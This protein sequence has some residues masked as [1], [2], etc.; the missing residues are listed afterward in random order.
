MQKCTAAEPKIRKEILDDFY[1]E[2]K[3]VEK[4]V[5]VHIQ[6]LSFPRGR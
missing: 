3:V 6:H 1:R 5:E 2:E 4:L